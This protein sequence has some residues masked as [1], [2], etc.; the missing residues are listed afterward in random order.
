MH[1]TDE[2]IEDYIRMATLEATPEHVEKRAARMRSRIASGEIDPCDVILCEREGLAGAMFVRMVGEGQVLLGA[3]RL[4]TASADVVGELIATALV[5]AHELGAS[6]A[7]SRVDDGL[8]F[9]G[10]DEA[11][12]LAG[13]T[14][15]GRRV[16]YK[17]PVDELPDED[18]ASPFTWRTLHEFGI[19]AFAALLGEVVVGDPGWDPSDEP[20]AWLRDHLPPER[21]DGD[22]A[23]IGL[24]DGEPAAALVVRVDAHDGWSS[25]SYMGVRPAM[26]G[27]GL[28]S[29]LQRRGFAIMRAHDGRLYHDG[30]AEDN[31]P[32]RRVFERH[33]C[34]EALRMT[35]WLRESPVDVPAASP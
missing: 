6:R 30:C 1:L 33:G 27:R 24:V 23:Q 7:Y 21:R 28:G 31:A 19:D 15:E 29:H 32:M 11:L 5:R 22:F 4:R 12:R 3:A 17:T 20:H 34:H 26:R 2:R 13:F 14:Q 18:P 16:E 9:S 25:I 8:A 35:E 10:Y